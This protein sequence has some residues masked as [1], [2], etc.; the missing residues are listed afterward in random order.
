MPRRKNW[1][2]A[3]AKRG[4]KNPKKQR[5]TDL[6]WDTGTINSTKSDLDIDGWKDTE[7]RKNENFKRNETEKKKIARQDENY[8]KY[9]SERDFIR[10][11]EYTSH[12]ENLENERLKKQSSRQKNLDKDRCNE[13][14]V[15]RT[16]RKKH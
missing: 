2:A 6:T 12:P 7:A 13:K 10:K 5:L 4:V 9:E 16:K 14:T 1:R 8:R 3:E 11:Q 15:K